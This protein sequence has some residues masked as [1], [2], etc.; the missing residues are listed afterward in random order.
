MSR[1]QWI[2]GLCALWVGVG[3]MPAY[4]ESLQPFNNHLSAADVLNQKLVTQ[5]NDYHT[6]FSLGVAYAREQRFHQAIEAF[7]RVITL[8]PSLAEPHNNLAVIYNELGDVKAAVVELEKSLLKHPGYVIAE[9]NIADLYVK[10][11]LQ[12][13][14]KA[15]LKSDDLALM[16]RY[17]RLLHV[18]DPAVVSIVNKT[19]SKLSKIKDIEKSKTMPME[20]KQAA[21]AI[22]RAEK[23]EPKDLVT[24]VVDLARLKHEKVKDVIL[25]VAPSVQVQASENVPGISVAAAEEVLAA[26]EAWRLAWQTQNMKPYFSAYA[27]DYVPESRF[28]TLLLWRYYKRRIIT[29]KIYIKIALS[30]VEVLWQGDGEVATVRFKQDFDSNNYKGTDMKELH[31]EKRAQGWKIIYEANIL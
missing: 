12:Y 14:K 1:P 4:A 28:S 23:S 22:D 29:N 19:A 30:G 13:Y 20:V 18:R 11:A 24:E 2:Y 31:M 3:V 9:E 6:W 8:A 5:P 27:D 15:L 26:L 25:S 17:E 7:R 10:L 21:V 16:Q